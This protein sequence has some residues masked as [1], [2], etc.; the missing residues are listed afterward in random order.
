M[1]RI[2]VTMREGRIT[3]SADGGYYWETADGRGEYGPFATRADA[4]DDH[5]TRVPEPPER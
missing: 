2:L 3:V 4:E 1:H 5:R